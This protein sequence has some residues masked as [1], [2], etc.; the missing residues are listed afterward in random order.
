MPGFDDISIGFDATSAGAHHRHDAVLRAS[1]KRIIDLT[2]A[3]LG[4]FCIPS[5]NG[6]A[7]LEAPNVHMVTCGGQ[8]TLPIVAAV[9]RVAR[10]EY[11]GRSPCTERQCQ[12]GYLSLF[13][14]PLTQKNN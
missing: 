10:V 3:A 14:V 8:A 9:A 12:Y 2:P 5:V 7:H 6:L 11:I 4:P 13:A 1:G